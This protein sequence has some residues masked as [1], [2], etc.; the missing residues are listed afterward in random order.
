MRRIIIFSVC[1]SLSFFTELASAAGYQLG[2]H[3]AQ[4]L[5]RSNAGETA[6]PDSPLSVVKNPANIFVT[7]YKQ[8]SFSMQ[9]VKFM[10][11]IDVTKN[12][13]REAGFDIKQPEK[14]DKDEN[15][16]AS[17]VP[18][19]VYPRH[20][21]KWA[22]AFSM[23]T[24]FSIEFDPKKTISNSE[25]YGD[26]YIK[27][28]HL[29]NNFAYKVT[30]DFHVGLGLSVMPTV[31]KLYR[32]NGELAN[33]LNDSG[34]APFAANLANDILGETIINDDVFSPTGDL[35]NFQGSDFAFNWNLGATYQVNDGLRLGLTY[36][37]PIDVTWEGD[38][39]SSLPT[40]LSVGT[41]NQEIDA[42][43]SFEMPQWA[44]FAVWKRLN[45]KLELHADVRWTDWGSSYRGFSIQ[46]DG[47]EKAGIE[48]QGQD[49]W[50]YALGLSYVLNE[51][52]K[53]RTGIAQDSP[54]L[55]LKN[56]RHNTPDIKRYW[57]SSGFSY[58]SSETTSWDASVSFMKFK[59]STISEPSLVFGLV[60]DRLNLG[61]GEQEINVDSNTKG[62]AL[63]LGLQYNRKF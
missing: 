54:Y 31:F 39:K 34:I 60:N 29:T 30:D 49:A 3:S 59:S 52:W 24:H 23:G 11:S 6:S 14:L 36:H 8:L 57:L 17:P 26:V 35:V 44:E 42:E 16:A 21:G 50:R 1:I 20:F 51:R 27:S 41:N 28:T 58:K 62:H 18:A 45:D 53:L 19:L 32:R 22:W 13:Y 63:I 15:G 4:S 47:E 5:G 43:V 61:W 12:P 55:S 9:F 10:Y 25:A 38:Y 40:L 33:V 46:A 7:E 2:I 56:R 48:T 37:A